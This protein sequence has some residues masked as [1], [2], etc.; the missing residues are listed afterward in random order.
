MLLSLAITSI[1]NLLNYNVFVVWL[2][3]TVV[4][5]LLWTALIASFSFLINK[6]LPEISNGLLKKDKG[7]NLDITVDEEIDEV[8]ENLDDDEDLKENKTIN[9]NLTNNEKVSFASEEVASIKK[10]IP[11]SNDEVGKSTSQ[12]SKVMA[13]AVRTVMKRE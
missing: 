10:E 8:V 5:T 13:K 1:L 3:R 6:Y 2:W 7:S 4:L 11:T 12:N 9:D